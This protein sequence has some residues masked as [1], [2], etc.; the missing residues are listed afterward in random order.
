MEEPVPEVPPPKEP[1]A[2]SKPIV[3]QVKDI[4]KDVLVDIPFGTAV[5]NYF[6][7]EGR[8]VKNGWV[9]FV[10][11]SGLALWIGWAWGNSGQAEL[12]SDNENLKRDNQLL[13]QKNGDLELT[14]APLIARAAKEFPGEEINQ[15]LK[16]IVSELAMKDPLN[17]PIA[18]GMATLNIVV[19]ANASKPFSPAHFMDAGAFVAFGSVTD[20][21][22]L[23]A[24]CHECDFSVETNGSGVLNA[25]CQSPAQ[26]PYRGGGNL[27]SRDVGGNS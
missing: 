8:V 20:N 16:K 2:E 7:Q 27:C 13:S 14:V 11:F 18:T 1:V 15:S 21:P 22:L 4:T 24:N 6:I 26:D 25:V 23:T 17:Q 9:A 12:R 3:S 5:Y 19:A 10:V